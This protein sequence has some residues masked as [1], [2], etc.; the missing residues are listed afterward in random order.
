MKPDKTKQLLKIQ[1]RLGHLKAW[2]SRIEYK[3]LLIAYKALNN[4]VTLHINN[5]LVLCSN[6]A[7]DKPDKPESFLD[8]TW[9]GTIFCM[10]VVVVAE[11]LRRWI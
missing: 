11:R 8:G 7:R 5:L 4:T 6:R 1:A 9:I 3:I 2:M 10:H